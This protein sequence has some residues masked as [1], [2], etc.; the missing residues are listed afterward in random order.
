MQ[1]C[2]V[3][4]NKFYGIQCI[5]CPIHGLVK[6]YEWL[7]VYG[8]I[9]CQSYMRNGCVRVSCNCYVRIPENWFVPEFSVSRF[10][11][12]CSIC[13]TTHILLFNCIGDIYSSWYCF[14]YDFVL[15]LSY[16]SELLIS[17]ISAYFFSLWIG[18]FNIYDIFLISVILFEFVSFVEPWTLS[19]YSSLTIPYTF[20]IVYI[21]VWHYFDYTDFNMFVYLLYLI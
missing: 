2:F 12:N 9:V 18:Y 1:I 6:L 15:F 4:I 8:S 19:E 11:N 21:F 20:H 5:G 14:T 10:N 13:E 3:K 16:S 7:D 17:K